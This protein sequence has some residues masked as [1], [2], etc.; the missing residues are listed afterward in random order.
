R[1]QCIGLVLTEH[2]RTANLVTLAFI[3]SQGFLCLMQSGCSYIPGLAF[4]LTGMY[5]LIKNADKPERGWRTSV[6]AGACLAVSIG[7]WLTYVCSI[8]AALAAPVV[9]YGFTKERIRLVIQTAAALSV[10]ALLIF[11][12]GA[13]VRGVRSVDDVT[14]GV[15]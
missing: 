8:P 10:A 9:L 3:V 13:T 6:A 2:Q 1:I 7:F 15:W 5:L 4:L 14:Q 11:G 12:A